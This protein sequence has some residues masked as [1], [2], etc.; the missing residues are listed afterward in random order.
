M[1]TK[2]NESRSLKLFESAIKS[3]YTRKGYHFTLKKF[4]T[5]TDIDDFDKLAGLPEK[6]IQKILEDYV[7]HLKTQNMNPNSF[8]IMFTSLQLFFA[9]N[10]KILNWKKIKKFYPD[11][12]KKIGHNTYTTEQIQVLLNATT[13]FRNRAIILIL[14]ST[15][16]RV[17]ALA[18]LKP[19]HLKDMPD[20]CKRVIIYENSKEEYPAFL[21]PE[22]SKV[23]DQYLQKRQKN[24][25]LCKVVQKNPNA[26]SQRREDST[27]K[28]GLQITL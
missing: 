6:E 19:K 22:T 26:P 2:V 27:K 4:M 3:D 12:I 24:G 16:C 23:I 7:I 15:G 10:D 17:G 1:N 28:R 18:D 11:T 9:M 21:T 8:P 20:G 14:A 25:E 5:F 13:D